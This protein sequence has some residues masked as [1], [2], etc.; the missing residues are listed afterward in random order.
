MAKDSAFGFVLSSALK[1]CAGVLAL[2]EGM[3]VHAH[4]AKYGY[5][6]DIRIQTK[7]IDFYAK[8]RLM[9]EAERVFDRMSERDVQTWNTMIGGF[10]KSRNMNTATTLFEKMP[11][12][13]SFTWETMLSGYASLG[14]MDRAQELF[15]QLLLHQGEMNVDAVVYTAMIVGYAKC[16]DVPAARL[17][18]D[19]MVGKDVVSWSAMI[20]AYTQAGIYDEGVHLFKLMLKTGGNIKPNRAI[21]SSVLSASAHLGSIELAVW[22]KNYIYSRGNELLNTRTITALIDMHA[23]CGELDEAYKIF[24]GWKDKDI[25]CYSAMIAGFGMHSRGA[26]ALKIFSQL[27]EDGLTPDST[28]FIVVLSACSHAGLVSEGLQYFHSM[29]NEYSIP[30]TADHYM[31]MVDLLGRAGRI[32]DAYRTI[33]KVMPPVKPHAGVWGALLSACRVYHNLEI[34]EIAAQHLLE[35]EPENA[36]NYVLLANM[37]AKAQKWKHVANVRGL[38]KIRGTEKRPGCSWIEI[39]GKTHKF[40]T[41]D[42]HDNLLD[43][44]IQVLAG[45]LVAEGYSPI[46]E[47]E[48]M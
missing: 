39:G 10:C 34:G 8:C 11:E 1:A 28:C 35:I 48:D 47:H 40:L 2:E 44:I 12:Q 36:G 15:D 5:R 41:G 46:V 17:V 16:G 22:V 25:V 6:E 20:S 3:Q 26:E 33:V 32:A 43:M 24:K 29:Q 14:Q 38:M 13:N 4:V 30:P 7:L 27:L 19:K 45:N 21:I 9:E 18:F 37:Y 42:V 23:K 31:C